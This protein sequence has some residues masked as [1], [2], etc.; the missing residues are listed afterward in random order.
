MKTKLS[1]AEK[2][3]I[4]AT[5]AHAAVKQVR[6]YTGAPYIVHPQEVVELLKN[7][8][9]GP[10]IEEQIASGWLHDVCEDCNI[11][12][13]LI[14]EVFGD[15][16]AELVSALT[17]VSKSEDGNRKIRKNIDLDHTAH[18]NPLAKSVKLADLISNSKSI[19]EHDKDFA[20]VYLHEKERLLEVL[21][22]GDPGLLAEA[23]RVL[24]QLR[25][26]L[27]V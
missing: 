20:R 14:R 3:E 22:D 26:K 15:L 6:K 12:L 18:A 7:H 24:K 1:L 25:E 10:I 17:D 16:V 11:T 4:F 8:S 27:R 19:V 21:G 5:A 2:A 23:H 9:S 13:E